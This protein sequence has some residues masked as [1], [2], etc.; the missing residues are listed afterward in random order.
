MTNLAAGDT[1]VGSPPHWDDV[2]RLAASVRTGVVSASLM[3]KRLGSYPRQNGV[4]LAL[5]EI[6]RIER[7][8]YTLD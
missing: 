3:L 7:T 8:V 6:G 4:A 5:H 2:L 1:T